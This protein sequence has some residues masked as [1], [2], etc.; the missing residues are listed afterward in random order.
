MQTID[1]LKKETVKNLVR[2]AKELGIRGRH[3][4]IKQSLI[5]AVLSAMRVAKN[6]IIANAVAGTPIAFQLNK[7]NVFLSA[8]IIDNNFDIQSLQVETKS[9][10]MYT[11]KYCKVIW[12]KTGKR[13]PSG[14]YQL[15]IR[16]KPV[17]DDG[18]KT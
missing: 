12:V 6:R 16:S 1:D 3:K 8:R 9:G 15:L 2:R 17:V 7:R 5:A 10:K 4:M 18:T 14:V 11:I 13:W